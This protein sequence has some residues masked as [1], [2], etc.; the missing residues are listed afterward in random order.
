MSHANQF[1]ERVSR[2]RL[3]QLAKKAEGL[4]DAEEKA[5]EDILVA[6]HEFKEENVSNAAIAGMFLISPTGVPA[7]A[8]KGAEILAARKGRKSG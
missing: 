6:I 1:T 8:V 4:M 5:G 2:T 3:R 7:K